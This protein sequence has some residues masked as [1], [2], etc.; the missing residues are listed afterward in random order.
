M[1]V[2]VTLPVR[3]L[4]LHTSG[5]SLCYATLLCNKRYY[6]YFREKEGLVVLDYSPN[7][8]RNVDV[9]EYQHWIQQFKPKLVILPSVDYS[10]EKTVAL[11]KSF[12]EQ[13]KV[14]HPVGVIQG[15]NLDTLSACYLFLRNYC[16]LIA[17]P[18]PLETIARREE[19]ARDLGIKEKL[20][21]LEV[22][23]NPYEEVPPEGAV[24]ICTSFPI[25]LAQNLRRL[26]EFELNMK[27]PPPLDFFKEE[28][29]GELARDNIQEYL[30]VIKGVRSY[31]S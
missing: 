9:L 31:S 16:E 7:L 27:I 25:R 13:V 18:S 1:L 11:S 22:Y 30:E 4:K 12:L 2:N 15:H 28:L 24:G 29:V 19:I 20:L 5:L 6:D 8:P 3:H 14:K 10:A 26:S 17:L 23:K 21:Y